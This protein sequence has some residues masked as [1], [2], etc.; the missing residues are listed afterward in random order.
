MRKYVWVIS[1][2]YYP[3]ETSTGYFLT[4]IA[5]GLASRFSVR[6]L[7]S[8]PT[9]SSRGRRAL[10]NEIRNGVHIHRCWSST[11]NKDVMPLRLLNVA[12]ISLSIFVNC[13]RR[14]RSGDCVIVVTNPPL[15]PFVVL[16]A[17]RFCG[18]ICCLLIHDVYPEVLTA[19]GI[20]KQNSLVAQG[21]G[22]LTQ[23]LYKRMSRIIVLGRDM[24]ALAKN[25]MGTVDQP[26]KIIPN[27]SDV[28]FIRPC[29]CWPHPLLGQ[30]G[31]SDRFVIQ[32]SGNIGRTHGVEQLV[33]CAEQ[34]E[35]DSTVHFL[36]IG[37]GGKKPWLDQRVR[38][39]GLSNVT[40]MDYRPR[41]E[42]AV[43]LT[44]CDVAIIS[45]IRGM[46]GVSVPSRMYNV[47]AA[48][49]PIIAIADSD[50]ELALVVREEGIGWVVSPG[51]IS[52]LRK[53]ILEAKANPSLLTQMGQRARQAAEM[54]YSFK[55]IKKAYIE[56]IASIYEEAV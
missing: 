2:L 27:W 19:S 29:T 25:K 8:Q 30:L 15:L 26:I 18:S 38:K 14:F 33:A 40:I 45:F 7:C 11:F 54:K 42:L 32:Y 47:M 44:A 22:W 37:F 10:A 17:S 34:L 23:Q 48:G 9:Y 16:L 24:A 31:L 6:V 3:E 53:A 55:L 21:I 39:L 50:S 35:N 51:D 12:S 52:G 28:D 20:V 36:F 56:M 49:R 4:K 5:E 46:A 43:S 13:L 41:A 1:E